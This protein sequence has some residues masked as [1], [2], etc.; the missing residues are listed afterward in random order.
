MAFSTHSRVA[1]TNGTSVVRELCTHLQSHGADIEEATE[2]TTISH[3]QA[4]ARLSIAADVLAI[5]ISAPTVEPLYFMRMMI[6]AHIRE[7]AGDP[8]PVI[9]WEGDGSEL[10]H[11]PNFRILEVA[12]ICDLT[13]KMRRITLAGDVARYAPLDMLHLNILVQKPGLPAPQWPRVGE[14]G[15]ISWADPEKRPDYRKYTARSVDVAR[16]CVDVDFVLHA[17]AGPG[18]DY[19]TQAKIGDRIGVVGPGGAGLV[20]ADWYCFA[21][22]ET[23]LPAI[24]RMLEHLPE[25]AR[26]KAF[27]E[28]ADSSEI[29]P[30]SYP[31]D[32]QLVWLLREG[33]AAGTTELLP[34]AVIGT[35]FPDD[36]SR[37]YLWAGCEF[38]AFKTIRAH[39]R[40]VVGLKRYEHLVVSYWRRGHADVG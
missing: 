31:R 8:S 9:V 33:A 24:A 16:G 26:G 14:D 23:A 34:D 25:G 11:P 28:V 1:L 39:A 40:Q 2:A 7:F 12:A 3:L 10:V 19:A 18:S 22:D 15:L 17:D 4:T 29:Q 32:M 35:E 21:G 5:D 37:I 20:E 38:S 6:A 36:G 27:I 30:V 13:P